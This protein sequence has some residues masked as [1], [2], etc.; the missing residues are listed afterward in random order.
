MTSEV[1]WLAWLVLFLLYEIPQARDR[2]PGGTLS[3]TTWAWFGVKA[4]S[5]VRRIILAAFMLSL[6]VHL[7]FA[8]SVVPVVATALP[9][10]AVIAV[11]VWRRGWPKKDS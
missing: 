6:T 2:K 1:I 10:I 3:E 11:S 7:V 9:L 5:V 8:T 4:G